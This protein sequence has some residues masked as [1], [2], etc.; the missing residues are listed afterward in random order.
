MDA[1]VAVGI[2]PDGVHVARTA[3]RVA[4]ASAGERL[5]AVTDA[6]AVAGTD[7]TSFTLNDRAIHRRNGRL[8]LEDGTLAG[9]DVSMAEAV[10]WMVNGAGI[11][12]EV[13]LA[14]VTSRP[15]RVLGR[16]DLGVI[17]PGARA[18]LVHLTEDFALT[19]VLRG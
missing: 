3:F 16:A 17:A 19:S 4:M 5:F 18:D 14:M 9:A 6:M 2:I 15:A 7:Q 13:A 10:A 1:S 8:T 12:P 11:A